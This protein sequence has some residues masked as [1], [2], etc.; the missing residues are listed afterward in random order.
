MNT[1]K[2]RGYFARIEFD[3]E[4]RIFVGLLHPPHILPA[5]FGCLTGVLRTE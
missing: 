2:Y 4:D 5:F 1:M 3:D